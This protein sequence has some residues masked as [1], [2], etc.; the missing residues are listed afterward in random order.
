M[1]DK[2][3]SKK[4]PQDKLDAIL[5][6]D[7]TGDEGDIKIDISD[8]PM[9]QQNLNANQKEAELDDL[10]NSHLQVFDPIPNHGTNTEHAKEKRKRQDALQEY[11]NLKAKIKE[12]SKL[13]ILF[14]MDITGSMDSYLLETVNSINLIMEYATKICE[15]QVLI[16]FLGYRDF[17][18]KENQFQIHNFT[19]NVDELKK[20]ISEIQADGG[21]DTAEDVTGALEQVQL[22]ENNIIMKTALLEMTLRTLQQTA[23]QRRL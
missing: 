11:K 3:D 7:E 2:K 5:D 14:I 13:N 22:M 9:V 8:P 21:G 16:G 23:V 12:S 10:P 4:N 17:C 20:K 18:D 6:G 1:S 15:G 19:D